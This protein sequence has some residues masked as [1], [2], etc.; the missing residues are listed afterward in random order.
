MLGDRNPLASF[1]YTNKNDPSNYS[2]SYK[3]VLV[4]LLAQ[5]TKK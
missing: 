2:F 5:F 3:K 1:I 4:L